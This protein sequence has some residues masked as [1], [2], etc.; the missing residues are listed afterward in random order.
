[1]NAPAL[2]PG[3]RVVNANRLIP[4]SPRIRECFA[5][6]AS[7]DQTDVDVSRANFSRAIAQKMEPLK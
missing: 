4:I 6:R 1:M 3:R 2:G 7:L 5:E